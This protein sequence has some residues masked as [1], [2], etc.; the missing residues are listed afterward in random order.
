MIRA[1][2][3]G[4]TGYAGAELCR[5]LS[6][7]PQA[8]LAAVS[9]VSFEGQALS[10][11]YPAY[12]GV[13][14]MV[15]GTQGEV[16][17]KSDAVFAAL[18]HGLSQ[19]LAA[20][21]FAKGKVFI[22]LGADFRLE[23]EEDYR[24]WYGGTFLHPGLHALAVYAL[25]ELF[26]EQIR[27]KKIIANPGCYTTAVPLALAPAL[28]N[29][30][31]EKDGIIADC[32]SG[33]TGAGRK[34]SQNTHYPELNEGMSAYKV[35][36]HRHTP[37]M[38]Q[39]LSH[40]AGAPVKLT[41][42]PHLLPV[43]RGILATCYAKLAAGATMEQIQKAYHDA[44]D[45]EY[46]IRLLPQGIEADIKNVRYSNFCDI[47]LHADSRTGTLVAISAIDNMVKG[48]AGQAI[49]NMNLAFGIEETAGL[50]AL[51]PAF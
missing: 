36:C 32:K 42:V 11:I 16:V 12:R 38:E 41:F 40:V 22:D 46:F 27:G 4:A 31:I 48:A 49:Q 35:A 10:E 3:V 2:V 39:S 20:E 18:P 6:G 8:E 44:Y 23:N 45:S 37:E 47:S 24:E 43:N 9:S 19:E 7:H 26:R 15:C 28:K 5:L 51:P 25:P 14:D 34:P 13:C 21:C 1:G 29:G 50:K 30:L 33:V 17:E